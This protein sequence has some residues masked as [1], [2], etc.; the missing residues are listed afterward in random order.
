MTARDWA[1]YG[2]LVLQ[3]GTWQDRPVLNSARLAQCFQGSAALASYGLTWWLNVP[4][5]G[6][7]DADDEVPVRAFG[8]SSAALA[9]FAPSAPT[10]L[11]MAAGA[12]NQRLY[13][14]PSQNV[15]VVR[16]GEGGPWSDDEFLARLLG[17]APAAVTEDAPAQARPGG[18]DPN[19]LPALQRALAQ[20]DL[21]FRVKR[22][23]LAALRDAGTDPK[24][25]QAALERFLTPEQRRTVADVLRRAR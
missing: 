11:R 25:R 1:K 5:S 22:D 23:L 13:V 17:R 8:P 9:S 2:Q 16:F 6:T 12:G 7:I 14:L 21:S 18:E 15:V 10:D 19:R 20:L 24:A 4:F 3:G